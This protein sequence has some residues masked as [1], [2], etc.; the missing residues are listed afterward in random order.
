MPLHEL[1]LSVLVLEDD[2]ND[3]ELILRH[4]A[5]AG[6]RVTGR[7]ACRK[8]EFC[9]ALQ[10]HP[11]VILADYRLPTFGAREALELL[12]EKK[13]EI[14]VIIITGALSD[15]AAEAVI[16]L[17]AADYLLKDRLARLGTAVVRAHLERKVRAEKE[18]AKADY[19]R[20]AA[21]VEATPDFVGIADSHGRALYVNGAGRQMIGLPAEADLSTASLREIFPPE[22]F[23][24]LVKEALPGALKKGAWSGESAL[25][26]ADGK[27][28]PVSQVVIAHKDG[29]DSFFSTIARDMSERLRIEE[30]LRHSQER[31][32]AVWRHSA[33]AM[34][35]TSREGIIQAVNP[36]YC[37]LVERAEEDLVG[38][39]FYDAF[40]PGADVEGMVEKHK[41]RFDQDDHLLRQEQRVAFW[42]GKEIDAEVTMTRIGV[43]SGEKLVLTILRDISDRKTLEAR[44]LR[45]Q[46]LECIGALAGGIAHD[47]N[48]IL[49][50]IFMAGAMLRMP[51][52][53]A[54]RE[55]ALS[56]VEESAQRGA[57]VVRRLLLF[58][59]GVEGEKT[60][61]DAGPLVK[62]VASLV[63]RTFPRNIVLKAKIPDQ[64]P[65]IFAD[66]TQI[67]Q[68]LLNLCVNARDAMP[69][70]GVLTLEAR[71]E[72]VSP[73]ALPDSPEARSGD[74]LVLS[75]ADTGTGI[76]P[77]NLSQIFEP[78][79]S[80][81]DPE[82]G[83]GLGLSTSRGI[84][85]SHNGF[86]AVDTEVGKGTRFDIY[87]PTRSGVVRPTPGA[88]V[89]T[90]EGGR[91]E[92]ILVVDD[93][94]LVREVAVKLLEKTG[95]RT[96]AAG[97]ASEA[98]EILEGNQDIAAVVTDMV[99]P[100]MGGLE[101]LEQA[102]KM[103]P[104]LPAIAMSGNLDRDRL[105]RLKEIGVTEIVDKPFQ[106]SQL[107][108]AVDSILH[109]P[110]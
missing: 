23:Q 69:K 7:Q 105:Q 2:S 25:R 42:N 66:R 10:D 91:G 3:Y 47:F 92:V 50:P 54:E 61:V 71:S 86:I 60:H 20:M 103:R 19:A 11:D 56:T 96:I 27:E 82:K 106:A 17:G 99:M 110:V 94:D 31:L 4:L 59:R 73:D 93:E 46:R 80:T 28:I 107:L 40:P 78:F 64:L 34:R 89:P 16:E 102:R 57:D 35:L 65:T 63:Q 48:N 22:V 45:G 39:P 74:H 84:I 6:L 38:R 72:K 9:E 21:I 70:G 36:A 76:S 30:E 104:N 53:P 13:L 32:Q 62:E 1:H 52:S 8:A 109:E 87:L 55:K 29:P 97:L 43:E 88:V 15:E 98:L 58:A 67:H 26:A 90:G 83:T 18:T 95:Y 75:V 37:K 14:P 79:F 101:F 77:G 108:N 68:V 24:N 85:K 33:D 49:A 100:K 81:K 41:R 44:F 51:L 5:K 12:R